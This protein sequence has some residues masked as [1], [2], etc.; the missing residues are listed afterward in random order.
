[1]HKYQQLNLK[2]KLSKQ[3]EHDQNHR[4]GD[5]TEGFSREGEEENGGKGT[6]N[7]KHKWWV[8]NR[9]GGV[10]NSI[11]NGEAK[12]PVRTTLGHELRGVIAGGKVGE[13]GPRGKNWHN[14]NSIINKIYF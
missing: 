2:N 1:M 7:K 13:G 10:K 8:Q 11:G 4:N 6:G 3:A 14:C 5:H 9:Q 12:E